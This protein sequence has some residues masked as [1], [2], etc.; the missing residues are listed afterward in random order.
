MNTKLASMITSD[1]MLQAK[2]IS[3][4]TLQKTRASS[5]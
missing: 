1:L 5:S 2:Q 3:L 4:F